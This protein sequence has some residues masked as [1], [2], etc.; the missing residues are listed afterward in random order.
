MAAEETA[1]WLAGSDNGG[2]NS[3]F[4]L[5]NR[6]GAN[7]DD[8]YWLDSEPAAYG[9]RDRLNASEHDREEL[10]ALRAEVAK[11]KA[12]APADYGFSTTDC[13]RLGCVNWEEALREQRCCHNWTTPATVA[14]LRD[15]IAALDTELADMRGLFLD[16]EDQIA[17]LTQE[18][19]DYKGRNQAE[20][21][22]NEELNQQL[23]EAGGRIADLTQ[24][25]EAEVKRLREALENVALGHIGS[26]SHGIHTV[27]LTPESWDKVRMAL[28]RAALEPQSQAEGAPSANGGVSAFGG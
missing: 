22:R 18:R 14:N 25:L 9:L 28:A 10:V 3:W 8:V 13:Y 26:T 16:G 11:V 27:V 21:Y 20:Y 23:S 6:A 2:G 24:R 4:V 15:Q 1:Q 19:D 17:A 7:D 12:E 5:D